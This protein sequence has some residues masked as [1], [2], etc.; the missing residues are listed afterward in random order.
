MVLSRNAAPDL[1]R[2]GPGRK[3]LLDLSVGSGKINALLPASLFEQ[4]VWM[5]D[6]QKRVSTSHYFTHTKRLVYQECKG[7]VGC[8]F[9]VCSIRNKSF[10]QHGQEGVGGRRIDGCKFFSAF[11]ILFSLLAVDM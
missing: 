6:E 11:V 4:L 10:P 5:E 9:C 7:S 3:D 8:K 1:V 2:Q